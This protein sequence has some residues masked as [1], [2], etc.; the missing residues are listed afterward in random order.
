M[1][2]LTEVASQSQC[3]R[4]VAA[5]QRVSQ[6][7][8]WMALP[9]HYFV[10]FSIDRPPLLAVGQRRLARHALEVNKFRLLRI[11]ETMPVGTDNVVNVDLYG[12]IDFA[13][14]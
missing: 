12:N 4:S 8:A 6:M 10:V 11:N 5:K 3:S 1:L 14:G 2:R 13:G 9:G 7:F